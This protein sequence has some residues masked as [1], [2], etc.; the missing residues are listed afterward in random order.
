MQE[1]RNNG[2][3]SRLCPEILGDSYIKSIYAREPMQIE[4]RKRFFQILSPI[5]LICRNCKYQSFKTTPRAVQYYHVLNK[6][7]V[8]H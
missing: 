5:A 7:S 4:E 2:M 8:L 3:L 1:K 6:L